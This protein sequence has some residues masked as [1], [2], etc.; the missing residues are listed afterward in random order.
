[1]SRR[2]ARNNPP[3]FNYKLLGMIVLLMLVAGG[4]IYGIGIGVGWWASPFPETTTTTPT[5]EKITSTFTLFSYPDGE[6]VS[7]FIEMDLWEPK[8]SATFDDTDDVYTMS[9]FERLVTGKDADDIS[10]DLRDEP[11]YWAE[12]TGNSVFANTFILLIGGANRDYEFYVYQPTSDVNFNI[13]DAVMNEAFTAGYQGDS[14]HTLIADCPQDTRTPITDLHYGVGW[15]VSAT[16]FADYSATQQLEMWNEKNYRAQAR[17]L[18][19]SL[20]TADHEYIEGLEAYTDYFGIKVSFNTT[21]GTT[22]LLT[23][24]NVTVAKGEKVRAFKIGADVW[25][26]VTED[27]NFKI[28]AYDFKFEMSIGANISVS[29]V[30]SGRI[31]APNDVPVGFT[32]YSLIG[33]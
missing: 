30:A 3:K 17:Y 33:A 26:V 22:A 13:L 12:I 18:D 23:D 2:T 14:N 28:G 5:T 19:P 10:D 27:I 24:I 9:N 7:N 20:D 16:E 25:F 1:M 21:I 31:T 11:W 8:S 32:L 15:D 6:D 29:A 4:S